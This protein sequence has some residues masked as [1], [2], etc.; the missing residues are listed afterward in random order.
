MVKSKLPSYNPYKKYITCSPFPPVDR[1]LVSGG[2]L[3]GHGEGGARQY[4]LQHSPVLLLVLEMVE[5]AAHH[6]VERVRGEVFLQVREVVA[7]L[8]S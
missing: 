6:E 5:L 3:S 2:A 1:R 7:Q 4:L 8:A